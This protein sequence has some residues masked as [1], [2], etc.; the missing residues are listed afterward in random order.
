ME[1]SMP[2]PGDS[3][4]V[5]LR[6]PLGTRPPND[7]RLLRLPEFASPPE[8]IHAPALGIVTAV[9][10]IRHLRRGHRPQS[11]RTQDP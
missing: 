3:Y 4:P 11:E 10:A 7:D 8:L 5:W 6:P 9:F 2:A 1:P